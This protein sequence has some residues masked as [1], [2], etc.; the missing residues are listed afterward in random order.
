MTD[1]GGTQGTGAGAVAAP[2]SCATAHSEALPAT[3]LSL[4]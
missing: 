2:V 3:P 4:S 1:A